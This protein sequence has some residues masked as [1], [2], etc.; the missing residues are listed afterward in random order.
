MQLTGP[1]P[2]PQLTGPPPAPQLTGPPPAPQLTGPPPALQLTGPP[3]APQLTGP[4]PA[5]GTTGGSNAAQSVLAAMGKARAPQLSAADDDVLA[6]ALGKLASLGAPPASTPSTAPAVS[7]KALSASGS[8]SGAS[9][10]LKSYIKRTEPQQPVASNAS[11]GSFT[12][13][14]EWM[15]LPDG[16]AVPPGLDVDLPLDGRPRRA[17]IPP[18]WQ[19]KVWVDD[20][21]GFWRCD[22]TR[23][24]KIAALT[25]A[26]AQHMKRESVLL[27]LSGVV[28]DERSTVEEVGLFGRGR[29]LIVEAH[30]P[31]QQPEASPE[32][33]PQPRRST[34]DRDAP[35][36]P[37]MAMPRRRRQG[38]WETIN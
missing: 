6:A 25:L 1:P 23:D 12:P 22:V 4:P 2:A 36:T 38:Q 27:M 35:Y 29:E 26:A 3:P 11:G 28:L 7:N 24:T 10:A 14:Y 19:L 32:A 18:R 9:A 13:T 20:E 21:S 31:S 5:V 34:R 30:L 15:E 17:R 16:I 8:Q 37:E 33:P